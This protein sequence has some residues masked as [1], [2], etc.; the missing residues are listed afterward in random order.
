MQTYWDLSDRE[1]SALSRDDVA[2]YGDAELMLRGVLKPKPLVLLETVMPSLETKTVFAIQVNSYRKLAI[3]FRTIEDARAVLKLRPVELETVWS[4][5]AQ[6]EVVKPLTEDATITEYS[7]PTIEAATAASARLKEVGAAKSENDR[8]ERE[9]GEQSR[10]VEAALSGLWEDWHRCCAVAGKMTRILDTFSEY[11]TI[12]GNATT[13]AKF[14]AKA[15]PE[16]DIIDASQWHGV[17]M[18]QTDVEA[19]PES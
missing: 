8:R 17:D 16:S 5:A 9:H 19:T 4:V 15:F 11:E 14:L 6:I 7:A 1:R 2:K 10:A 13:A 12:A 3:A 18:G